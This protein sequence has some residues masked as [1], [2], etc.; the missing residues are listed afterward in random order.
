MNGIKYEKQE[1]I[2]ILT[3]NR[4][5]KRNALS[6][7]LRLELHDKLK[8]IAAET[9]IRAMVITG[10]GE[11]FVAG[12]DIATMKGYDIQTATQASK[13]GSE[14]FYFI[15]NMK[16]PVIAAINGWALG[17]GCELALACDIRI[18]SE[19]AKF[20]QTEV[21]IGIL[22][23]Y[24]ATI[25][26]PR[27]V[28]PAKAKELIFSGRIIDA[29]EAEKIGLVNFVVPAEELMD[30]SIDFAMKIARGPASINLAKQ[31]INQSFDLDM[32]GAIELSSNLYGEAYNTRDAFEGISAYLEK[33]KPVFTGK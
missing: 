25:R 17:G 21:R 2:A 30:R 27:L 29:Q 24:G 32:Q 10:A 23:G 28:G 20:G 9:D 8:T 22:P 13:E 31:S 1:K 18:C 19:T 14:I 26:L 3:I 6:R 16:V 4:P 33:R 15:E 11:A 7:E 12:A 5:E